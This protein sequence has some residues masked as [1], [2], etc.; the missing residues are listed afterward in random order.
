[1]RD[2]TH[3][4]KRMRV[5]TE[6]CSLTFTIQKTRWWWWWGCCPT[7][8]YYF[9]KRGDYAKVMGHL[10][11]CKGPGWHGFILICSQRLNA[12]FRRQLSSPSNWYNLATTQIFL[13]DL[14]TMLRY[15]GVI[16]LIC[17]ILQLLSIRFTQSNMH[18]N[19]K[20]TTKHQGKSRLKIGPLLIWL[21]YRKYNLLNP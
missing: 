18:C 11:G 20:C 15:V 17:H 5:S 12:I 4:S 19:S 10:Y 8:A 9:G 2:L 14:Q 16:W 13:N 3:P 1:M 21:W 6:L 7:V